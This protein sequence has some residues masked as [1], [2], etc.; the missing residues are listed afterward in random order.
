MASRLE[1]N[2][3]DRS[4]L[5]PWYRRAVIDPVLPHI[6]ARVSPNA[7]THFGHLANLGGVAVLLGLWPS[8]GYA[9]ALAAVTI[10]IHVW[11]DNAD[12][13]H[14]RRTGQCSPGGEFLDH[15]LDTLNVAYIGLISCAALG[16]SPAWWVTLSMLIPTA[17]AVTFWEQSHTGTFRLG[18]L[19]QVESTVLL[20]GLLL[21]AAV[22]GNDVTT[23]VSLGGVT[24]QRALCLWTVI[25]IGVGMASGLARVV[26]VDPTALASIAPLA[27]LDAAVGAGLAT[28]ALS[29]PGAVAVG[30]AGNVFVGVQMLV[31][32]LGNERPRIEPTVV[33]GAVVLA[34]ASVATAMGVG[35][36]HPSAALAAIACATYGVMTARAAREGLRRVSRLGE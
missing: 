4:I 31:R 15:G 1:Y 14:A 23:R 22:F 32:R 10:Q 33:A 6:P 3:E 5:L 19:N 34:A 11:C 7:L 36:A 21:L 29:A 20:S 27:A 8:R 25:Q 12:G 9:F 18:R 28:G 26:R 13:G 30:V 35:G 2:V 17:A 16:V 24:L